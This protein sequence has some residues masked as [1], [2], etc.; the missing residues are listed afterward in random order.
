MVLILKH[1]DFFITNSLNYSPIRTYGNM[2]LINT[3]LLALS[4][5]NKILC[6]IAGL[7]LYVFL[8]RVSMYPVSNFITY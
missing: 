1:N 5:L 7:I 6:L 8:F 2:T 3:S 4:C